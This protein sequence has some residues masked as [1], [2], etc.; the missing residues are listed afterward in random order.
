[1]HLRILAFLIQTAFA[2]EIDF[3]GSATFPADV[4]VALDESIYIKIRNPMEMQTLCTFK[5]PGRKVSLDPDNFVTFS[6]DKC[7]IKIEKV[8]NF[9][10]GAW[11]LMST[12]KNL[13]YQNSVKGMSVVRVKQK[14]EATI[15]LPDQVFSSLDNLAPKGYNLSYC[16][17]TKEVG[18]T[19]MLVIDKDRCMIPQDIETDLKIGEWQVNMGVLGEPK[20][21][22]FSVNI[23]SKGNILK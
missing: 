20:E 18:L 21:I 16:H 9:H 13:T 7:G 23:Q 5:A 22:S 6:D 14:A 2:L 15:V 10:A 12:F 8:Q 1:M 4:I 19:N 17:V 11:T 3:Y